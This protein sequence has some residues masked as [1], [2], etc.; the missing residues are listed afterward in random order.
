MEQGR[1]TGFYTLTDEKYEYQEK[2]L[3]AEGS[4]AYWAINLHLI[5]IET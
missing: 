1:S 4:K 2:Y 5:Q 3:V